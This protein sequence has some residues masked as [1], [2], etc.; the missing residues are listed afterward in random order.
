[1]QPAE[2]VGELEAAVDIAVAACEGD[3]RDSEGAAFCTTKDG[4]L[5]CLPGGKWE[6]GS[7][8]RCNNSTPGDAH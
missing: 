5:R 2:K 6:M 3:L 4:L 7:N 8:E 1:M